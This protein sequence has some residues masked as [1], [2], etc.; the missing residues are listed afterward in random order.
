ML[1]YNA[2]FLDVDGTLLD[3]VDTKNRVFIELLFE[4]GMPRSFSSKII[5][6]SIALTRTERFKK[7]WRAYHQVEIPRIILEKLL[8]LSETRLLNAEYEPLPGADLFLKT[9]ESLAHLHIVSS[10]N[11]I[12]VIESF[13]RLGWVD[14]FKSIHTGIANKSVVFNKIILEF[15][16]PRNKCLSVGDTQM[17]SNAAVESGIDYW[18]IEARAKQQPKI[19]KNFVGQS[20]DFHPLIIHLKH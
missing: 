6:E 9:Y 14:C 16:Y 18:R 4:E 10:A 19:V 13:K 7:V 11:Q 17:D 8:T 3:S 2:F 1:K 5:L 20:L 12:E 15:A